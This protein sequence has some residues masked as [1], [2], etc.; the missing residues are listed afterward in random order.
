MPIV[1]SQNIIYILSELLALGAVCRCSGSGSR[2]QAINKMVDDRFLGGQATSSGLAR[3]R[4]R[5]T[6]YTKR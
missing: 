5:E 4:S 3:K 1:W 6:R 2:F